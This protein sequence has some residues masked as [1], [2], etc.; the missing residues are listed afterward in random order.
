ME[1]FVL[2]V[3][4]L[5]LSLS[6]KTLEPST[7]FETQLCNGF[8]TEALAYPLVMFWRTVKTGAVCTCVCWVANAEAELHDTASS[9]IFTLSKHRL[10]NIIKS[11]SCF[12]FNK[13]NY[14]E[15]LFSKYILLF[16]L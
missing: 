5:L 9:G 10:K 6:F 11:I 13:Q 16:N 3:F 4:L 12:F 1:F 7:S 2:V 14:R 15:S 8:L